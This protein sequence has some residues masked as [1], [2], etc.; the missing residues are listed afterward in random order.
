MA[1]L[2]PDS[3]LSL[4]LV[5]YGAD[6]LGTLRRLRKPLI[7]EDLLDR[8]LKADKRRTPQNFFSTLEMLFATG[9]IEVKGY[10]VTLCDPSATAVTAAGSAV[11]ANVITNR[12]DGNA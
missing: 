12:G 7:V 10:K 1:I 8:F 11:S 2:H 5:F 4:S 6:V 3:D 9:T